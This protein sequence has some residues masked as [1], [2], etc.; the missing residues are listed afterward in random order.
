LEDFQACSV[1]HRIFTIARYTLY[2]NLLAE[3]AC[4]FLVV[5]LGAPCATQ[6]ARSDGS[7]PRI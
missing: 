4:G 6:L 1:Q 2:P 5:A 3:R 7:L